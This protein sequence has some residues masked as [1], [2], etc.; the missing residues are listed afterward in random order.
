MS[1][2]MLVTPKDVRNNMI[3]GTIRE[4]FLQFTGSWK[5][6]QCH[7]SFSKVILL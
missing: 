3:A 5:L 6:A 1:L 4:S 2:K 7:E